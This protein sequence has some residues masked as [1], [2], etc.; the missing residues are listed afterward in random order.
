TD[1]LTLAA[2]QNR[3][4]VNFGNYRSAT[5]T[6]SKFNDRNADGCWDRNGLD[7]CLGTADDETGLSGWTIFVDYDGDGVLDANEPR[8]VT[9]ANGNYSI[10]GVRAGAYKIGEVQQAG[11]IRTTADQTV[12]LCPGQTVSGVNV[13]NFKGNLVM[14][15]DTATIGFWNNKNG[16]ALINSLN[17]GPTAKNLG[18]W[19]A[20]NFPRIYGSWCGANNL[21]GK[22][23]AQVA[24][25]FQTLFNRTGQ[26]LEAQVLAT[27][28]AAFVTSS[29]LAGGTYAAKYG[30]NVSAGGVSGDAYN[31]GSN[32]AA[33]GV[34]NNSLMTVWQIL[35]ATNARSVNG[36]L[37]NGNT[38]LRNLGNVVYSGINQSGDIIG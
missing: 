4:G 24:A 33:F 1:V 13:G 26:K 20:T 2:G 38:T 19:L 9:D 37:W 8:A 10:A 12:T 29:N 32:G 5:V 35:L 14:S 18:N 11:W 28:L 36:L 6:G 25:Y 30:F 21:S 3:T 7:N 15:G 23:N 16:Q 27:A 22:T 17:G 31:V 34:V